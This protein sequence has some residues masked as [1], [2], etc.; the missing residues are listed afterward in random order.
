LYSFIILIVYYISL[1]CMN[2]I[3]AY[4]FVHN[5]CITYL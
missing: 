2:N 5:T 4:M 1:M 3:N